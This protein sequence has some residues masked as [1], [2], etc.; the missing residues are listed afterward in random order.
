MLNDIQRR[1]L[2]RI[3]REAIEVVHAGRAPEW[4]AADF[5]DDLRRPAGAF[6]TLRTQSGDLRGCIGS[7]HPVHPLYHAVTSSAISAA[8]RD[9]RFIPVQ[10]E[11]LLRLGIEI[12]V[13]GPIE[14]VAR[15]DDIMVGRDGL[16]VSRG[17]QA[18][19]LL[20]QVATEYGW[21]RDT[22][23]AQTCVKAGLPPTAW[24]MEDTRIERFAAEVFGE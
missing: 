9:P 5:D 16:I 6:V 18:G 1:Q 11:E 19:L 17:R 4:S 23:L 20:P 14:R 15:P 22:F 8:F 13:M 21:E 2:L 7:I 10:P 3:A 24:C 12:S